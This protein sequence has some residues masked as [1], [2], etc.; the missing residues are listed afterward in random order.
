MSS[1][2]YRPLPGR[3]TLA[4]QLSRFFRE[5]PAEV[6]T[7][8]QITARFGFVDSTVRAAVRVL[9]AEGLLERTGRVISLARG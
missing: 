1:R 6:L 9:C 7:V 3:T 5:N 4:A 8:A 2:V